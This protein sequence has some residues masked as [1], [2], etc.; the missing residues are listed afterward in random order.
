MEIDDLFTSGLQP[1]LFRRCLGWV[2]LGGLT[3]EPEDM[4]QKALESVLSHAGSTALEVFLPAF[5]RPW[6]DRYELLGIQLRMSFSTGGPL[7]RTI[8]IALVRF[9]RQPI[10]REVLPGDIRRPLLIRVQ[11]TPLGVSW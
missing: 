9:V 2:G 3:T 5:L 6:Q 1:P 10:R 4:S 11:T 8:N 7:Y